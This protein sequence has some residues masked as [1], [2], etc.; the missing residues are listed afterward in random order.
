MLTGMQYF[1]MYGI[2][3]LNAAALMNWGLAPS[4][5]SIFICEEG[6]KLIL[7][8]FSAIRFIGYFSN[9]ISPTSVK[10]CPL[11]YLPRTF[12]M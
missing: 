3:T 4:M 9:V 11:A 2:Y 1:F 12:Q 5:V 8:A 7:R 10:F 6:T